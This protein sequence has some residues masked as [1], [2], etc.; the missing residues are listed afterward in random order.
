M[1]YFIVVLSYKQTHSCDHP[2]DI[3]EFSNATVIGVNIPHFV[4]LKTRSS[5]YCPPKYQQIPFLGSHGVSLN[6][7][8]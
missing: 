6:P 1:D 2:V 4:E 3:G 7:D 5:H 8:L